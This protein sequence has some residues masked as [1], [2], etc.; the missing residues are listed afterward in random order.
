MK[1]GDLPFFRIVDS[2]FFLMMKLN[3]SNPNAIYDQQGDLVAEN[4]DRF[5]WRLYYES[6]FFYEELHL[7][8]KGKTALNRKDK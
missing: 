6:P 5:I 7:F 4:F 8:Y 2:C 3:S 1:P